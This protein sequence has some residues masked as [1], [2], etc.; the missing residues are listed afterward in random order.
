MIAA[1]RV[2]NAAG[3]N[4]PS[5]SPGYR[6]L[7][8]GRCSEQQRIYLV[9]T[10]C[11]CRRRMFASDHVAR[12]A[13]DAIADPDKWLGAQLL[14]WVLMPDH[15]HGLI[16]FNS[17]VR[18]ESVVASM[19]GRAARTVNRALNRKGFVW[20]PGF[21]DRALRT[22]EE[23]LPAARYIVA[24]PKRAGLVRRVGDYPYWDAIW[25]DRRA[26]GLKALPQQPSGPLS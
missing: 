9:T 26:S 11:I 12:V 18:L 22:E 6:A 2:P 17:E 21:H 16:R 3:M 8:R 20:M 4:S 25:T 1:A 5:D 14:C 13:A 7:R 23:L 24:N 15:W 19:K 10:V